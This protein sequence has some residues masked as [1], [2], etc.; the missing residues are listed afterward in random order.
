MSRM[1]VR[2]VSVLVSALAILSAMMVGVS[3]ILAAPPVMPMPGERFATPAERAAVLAAMTPAEARVAGRLFEDGARDLVVGY[4]KRGYAVV[5][6]GD[7]SV[8]LEPVGVTSDRQSAIS[9]P[10]EQIGASDYQYVS[11][12]DLYIS[13]TV[14]RTSSNP[15]RFYALIYA[16]WRG[17]D[18]LNLGNTS[19]DRMSVAW[20]GAPA[21]TSSRWASRYVATRECDRSAMNV[22]RETIE[23]YGASFSFHESRDHGDCNAHWAY[24][25]V[26][27]RETT[28]QH[29]SGTV[30][31]TY[32]HTYSGLTY[33]VALRRTP[34]INI[35]PTTDQWPA[36]VGVG[37]TY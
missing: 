19:R 17:T 35:S 31:F 14:N 28:F 1:K 11:D 3:P 18:G 2:P 24:M 8:L 13:M 9:L 6:N 33:D 23:S 30:N 12:T 10:R 16:E 21:Y 22:V 32:H 36:S 25:Y 5:E 29:R 26:H 15:Y 7:G 20:S 34:S 4:A 27:F 37:Y